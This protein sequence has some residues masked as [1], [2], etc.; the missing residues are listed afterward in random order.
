[1]STLLTNSKLHLLAIE[2][3]ELAYHMLD[4]LYE[5]S[6]FIAHNSIFDTCKIV[7]WKEI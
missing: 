7:V 5:I 1:M 3:S 2:R 6:D 4:T